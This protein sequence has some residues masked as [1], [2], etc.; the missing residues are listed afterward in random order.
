MSF[1][2]F[3]PTDP[4]GKEDHPI[5][6]RDIPD[7]WHYWAT[8]QG[9]EIVARVIDK[10]HLLLRCCAC[11]GRMISKVFVLRTGTPR[12]PHC[13]ED[14]RKRL[15]VDAGVT[16]IEA[17]GSHDF[18]IRLRCGHETSRQQEFLERVRAGQTEI[19]CDACLE[20]R[21]EAEA[22]GRG[23]TL[24][25]PD[26]K[27]DRNYRLYRHECGHTQRVAIV[28]MQT[29]R[30]T[31]HACSD[32]WTN[33]P[34]LIYLMR[35]ILHSGRIAIKAGFSRN[36]ASRLRYQLV[37]DLEQNAELLRVI[38][39]PTGH[40]AICYEKRLHVTLR[41]HFPDAVLDRAEFEGEVRVLSE[42]YCASIEPEVLALL[43]DIELRVRSLAK[44]GAKL[45][46]RRARQDARRARN[47]QRRRRTGGSAKAG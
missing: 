24:L 36:P 21:L 11:G 20:A 9:Y 15:C 42:L 12:C 40:Q 25:D 18:R 8:A 47:R 2:D 38:P 3:D 16:F 6:D 29:G 32:T 30:F 10:N 34:S 26:P 22:R 33:D 7:H 5:Y 43:D 27:G 41:R 31:C 1:D 44:R 46:R 19:R 35:F 23:W 28:N 4:G 45:A 17:N 13:L 37:T 39:V 14:R